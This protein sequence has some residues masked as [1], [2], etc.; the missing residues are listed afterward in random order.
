MASVFFAN[1]HY[2]VAPRLPMCVPP[3]S[4]YVCPQTPHVCAPDSLCVCPQTPDSSSSAGRIAFY[5]SHH[6]LFIDP[7]ISDRKQPDLFMFSY[8]CVQVDIIK[9]SSNKY[10][11]VLSVQMDIIKRLK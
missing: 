6:E 7:E 3:D 11:V 10:V 9:I 4:L 5:S 8:T 1:V 2:S